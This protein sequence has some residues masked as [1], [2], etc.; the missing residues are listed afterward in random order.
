[1]GTTTVKGKTYPVNTWDQVGEMVCQRTEGLLNTQLS[2]VREII[3][4]PTQPGQQRKFV[5]SYNSDTTGTTSTN[6]N[7]S[8]YGNDNYTRT[9]SLG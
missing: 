3:F 1:M 7:W 2:V 4:P 9:A 8:C 6:V 5:F